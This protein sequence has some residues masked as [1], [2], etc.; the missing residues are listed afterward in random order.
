M[1][2]TQRNVETLV[3]RLIT[4]EDLRMEFL[5]NPKETLATLRSRGLELSTTEMAALAET[6]PALWAHA[7]SLLDVRLQ[8]ASLKNQFTSRTETDRV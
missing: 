8:K 7:A 4:D 2:V 3:G 1:T 6:D 5:A